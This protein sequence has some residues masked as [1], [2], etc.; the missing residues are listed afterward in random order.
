MRARRIATGLLGIGLVAIALG[1]A[2]QVFMSRPAQD[3]LAPLERVDIAALR[4]PLPRRA[5]W[6]VRHPIARLIRR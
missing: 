4:P 2:V 1:A 3:H 5:F 6:P